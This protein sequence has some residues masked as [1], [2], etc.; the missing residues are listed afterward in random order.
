MNK[1]NLNFL[2]NFKKEINKEF[3]KLFFLNLNQ[4]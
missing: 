4:N 2:I 3:N 1:T